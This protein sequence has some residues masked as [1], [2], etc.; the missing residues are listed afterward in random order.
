[1]EGGRGT[2]RKMFFASSLY[3]FVWAVG[4]G[5]WY[6]LSRHSLESSLL[7]V[8]LRDLSFSSGLASVLTC[9]KR[10][11][12]LLNLEIPSSFLSGKTGLLFSRALP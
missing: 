3:V 11:L 6:G 8:R 10:G 1:M 9:K 4:F 12:R 2:Y 5:R 7:T